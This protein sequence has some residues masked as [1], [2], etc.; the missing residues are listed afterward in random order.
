MMNKRINNILKT[1]AAYDGYQGIA[2]QTYLPV[3]KKRDLTDDE[4]KIIEEKSKKVFRGP[5]ASEG[6]LIAERMADPKKRVALMAALLTIGAGSYG[7]LLGA[8]TGDISNVKTG[9]L[10]GAATGL[11]IGA[12]TSPL[13]YLGERKR[14]KDIEDRMKRLPEG[15][16][17]RDMMSDPAVQAQENRN[18]LTNAALLAGYLGRR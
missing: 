2:A 9:G 17:L 13:V 1:A 14:N 5:F 11:G 7:A 18:N 10:I 12:L 15:A 8:A 16:T 6:D 4:Q 3:Q